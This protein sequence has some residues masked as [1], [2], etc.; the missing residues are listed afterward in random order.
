M[1]TRKITILAQVLTLKYYKI[2]ARKF[3]E[4]AFFMGSPLYCLFGV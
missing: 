3:F 4:R 1:D 2:L